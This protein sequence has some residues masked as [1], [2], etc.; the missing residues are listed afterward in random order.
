[1]RRTLYV[2]DLDGTLL[3]SNQRLSET[4]CRILNEQIANGV[5]FSYATA[6]SFHTART[7]TTGL[8]VTFPA[9]IYNGTMIKDQSS[10]QVLWQHH[11]E[12]TE[13]ADILQ[14]LLGH[15]LSPIVYSFIDTRERFSFVP[16]EQGAAA[17]AFLQ[18]RRD[19]ERY[20]PVEDPA[21]LTTGDVF[22]FTCIGQAD[23]LPQAYEQLKNRAR[24]LLQTDPY[25]GELWLECMPAGAGKATAARQLKAMVGADRL[26]VFGDGLN[27]MDLFRV[28]DEG[29]AVA[30]AEPPL[31]AIA[32]AVIGHHNEDSVALFIENDVK[33]EAPRS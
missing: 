7:V 25:T 20:H 29:Y 14:I 11:F 9:I 13:A 12:P 19:D 28:A 2:S 1:M 5:L 26:V 6:R 3:H 4:T 23:R 30:N 31:K 33:K 21:L 15:G 18:S 17:T 27:D 10:G 32:T 24:C 22:Y 16:S 8:K